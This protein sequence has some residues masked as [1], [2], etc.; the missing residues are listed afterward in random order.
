MTPEEQ[1]KIPAFQF[2][3]ALADVFGDSEEK[4]DLRVQIYQAKTLQDLDGLEA[5]MPADLRE[6][7][8]IKQLLYSRRRFIKTGYTAQNPLTPFI[9]DMIRK[10]RDQVSALSTGIT[11]EN[12][13]T[14]V[15]E[16]T[17]T[18][19]EIFAAAATLDFILG[20]MPNG[21][22]YA[23]SNTTKH[24]LTSLG[25][26]AVLAAVG[27]DPVKI[28]LL[29]PYQDSL[30]MTFRNRRPDDDALFQAYRTREL[31][32]E[33]VDDARK[34]TDADM[35]RIEADNDRIYNEEIAKW[36]YSQW[37]A[38]A[39]ARS[40]T[41]TLS[42]GNLM[43]LARMGL[44]DRGT[45]MY[46]L[47]GMGLDRVALPGALDALDSANKVSNYEG[48]RSMIEPSYVS[49]DIEE[50]DLI[51]YWDRINVP[52]DLQLWVLPRL[53]KSREKTLKRLPLSDY[54]RAYKNKLMRL[55]DVLDRM[56]GEYEQGDIELE[57]AL[58]EAGK[59]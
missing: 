23:S 17:S 43:A 26:G 36:G 58:L 38:T 42:F 35:D 30:E 13:E 7:P 46:N 18:V 4:R 50:S 52:K 8:D 12:A 25:L 48:F 28:G 1:R 51:E 39:L 29:R 19:V 6:N 16:I 40:A 45:A 31:S 59:A 21:E 56:R 5:T 55:E 14:A 11:P 57:R 10:W 41:R 49:G 53:R 24:L 54:E 34:L 15:A 32:P 27:H 2:L 47:W 37:F 22:G 44:L 3:N 9:E 20:A 33:K